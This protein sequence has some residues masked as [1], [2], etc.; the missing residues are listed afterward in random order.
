MVISKKKRF[1]VFALILP[2]EN[3][4]LT[5]KRSSVSPVGFGSAGI[6]RECGRKD[7]VFG[8]FG[9]RSPPLSSEH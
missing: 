7:T 8:W 2:F 1:S 5:K 9:L 4:D 3:G 6:E